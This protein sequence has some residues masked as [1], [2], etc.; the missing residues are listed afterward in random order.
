[1]SNSIEILFS[2]A[3]SHGAKLENIKIQAEAGD[4]EIN[5]CAVA[6]NS[7]L[8]NQEICFIPS[9]ILLSES[10]AMDST[11]GK[12]VAQYVTGLEIVSPSKYPHAIEIICLAIFMV[13]QNRQPESF[14]KPY[15]NCLPRK[16]NLPVCARRVDIKLLFGGTA[17]E[18]MALERVSWLE[19]VVAQVNIG[20][21]EYFQSP[22]T[23]DEILWAYASIISR[24][25][26]K[27]RRQATGDTSDMSLDPESNWITI[28]EICLY[29]VLDLLNHKR[30]HKIEWIMSDIGVSFIAREGVGHGCEIFNNYG[31]KGNEVNEMHLLMVELARKL[32]ICA[33][34]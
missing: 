14:W 16:Y 24:A 11:V 5:R 21:S 18:F 10:V 3:A 1:M 33:K 26:P 34:S 13:H 22:L 2:W 15:L 30:N 27:S 29:P 8:T 28:S 9:S 4:K 32:W 25:F 23:L 20:A 31:P 6:K 12:C 19:E 17:L 7:I